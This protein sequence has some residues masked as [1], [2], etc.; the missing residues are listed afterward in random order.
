MPSNASAEY[1]TSVAYK[2]NSTSLKSPI[3]PGRERARIRTKR[4]TGKSSLCMENKRFL[5]NINATVTTRD[6]SSSTS[7]KKSERKCKSPLSAS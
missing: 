7:S 5:A 2:S 6:L 3:E 1:S 4:N